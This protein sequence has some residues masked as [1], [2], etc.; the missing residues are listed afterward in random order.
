MLRVG[1]GALTPQRFAEILQ[2]QNR[3]GAG[4]AARACGLT[5]MAVQYD[6]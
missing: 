3:S 1:Y 2:T 6:A 5:L 4:P